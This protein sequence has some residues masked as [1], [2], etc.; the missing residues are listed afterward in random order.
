MIID[1]NKLPTIKGRN[2][3]IESIK[4]LLY[5]ENKNIFEILDFEDDSIYQEPLLFAYFNSDKTTKIDLNTILYGYIKPEKRQ[6]QIQVKSDKLGKIYLP[7]LGWIHTEKKEQTCTLISDSSDNFS[8]T[9]NDKKIDFKF[10]P[11]EIIEG[12]SIELLKYPVSL[13]DQFYYDPYHNPIDVEIENISRKHLPNLIKAWNL[14]KRL[15]PEQYNLIESVVIKNVVFNVDTTLRNSFASL[16]A[17]GISF[18]NAYQEDY[19]EVFFVDDIAHQT[20]HVIFY[21]IMYNSTEFL[22]IDENTTMETLR[23]A[24]EGFEDRNIRVIFHALYTYHT[25]FLCLNACL[26]ANVFSGSKKHESLG[27]IGFYIRKCYK[28]LSLIENHEKYPNGSKDIFTTN[29]LIIYD[30]IKNTFKNT[31]DLW[32]KEGVLDFDMSN[33]PYNFTYSKFVE[34]N[35]INQEQK[36]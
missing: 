35:P 23:L 16:S 29:G 19:N 1:N 34:L 17:N 36:V 7:N 32:E 13:L 4:I 18:F 21:S 10:E 28:D 11:L 33:Q 24:S 26:N 20:G 30:S 2:K 5:K 9:V 31:I 6:K 22:K 14:I 12:T 27:R 8:L 15:I 25:S 3:L